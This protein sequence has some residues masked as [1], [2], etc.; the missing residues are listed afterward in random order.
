MFKKYNPTQ[1]TI[2]PSDVWVTVSDAVGSIPLSSILPADTVALFL[3]VIAAG[4]TENIGLR[5]PGSSDDRT[6]IM[7]GDSH[8]WAVVGVD[9]GITFEAFLGN[10]IS[11]SVYLVG[12]MTAESGVMFDSGVSQ[13][14]TNWTWVEKDLS[15]IC[16]GAIA[17][18][19]EMVTDAM[20]WGVRPHGSTQDRYQAGYGHSWGVIG[21][22]ANQHIDYYQSTAGQVL[23]IIGYITKNAVFPVDAE[24]ISL[25]TTETYVGIDL[26]GKNAELAFIDVLGSLANKNYALREGGSG[27]NIYRHL[28]GQHNWG[29]VGVGDSGSIEG[30][31]EDTAVD[32]WL[33]GVAERPV[34]ST[35]ANKG[36]NMAHRLISIGAI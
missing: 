18:I 32:F 25:S 33:V 10:N 27:E 19:F 9:A 31:I 1:L 3:H 30:K 23:Y 17:V 15:A 16:P 12:Y 5:K 11:Q 7:P 4:A 21:C 20:F 29:I 13:T 34:I 8:Q 28:E 26:T 6:Q 14:G 22:D 2:T 24:D 35:L 36:P